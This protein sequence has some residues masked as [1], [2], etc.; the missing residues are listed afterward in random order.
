MAMPD[1]LL[2]L[3]DSRWEE[4][5]FEAEYAAAERAAEFYAAKVRKEGYHVFFEFT[6][7]ESQRLVAR[8][9]CNGYPAKAPDL[10][11]LDP[12]TNGVSGDKRHWPPDS[13]ILQLPDGLHLCIPGTRWF[14]QTHRNR[15]TRE[16]R[17]LARLLAVLAIC[18]NGQAQALAHGRRR[19][20]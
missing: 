8:L 16:D 9:E 17:G 7:R 2:G 13:P 15:G 19:R 18:C 11:F 1:P 3:P 6:G 12:E 4:P 14:E 5:G 20:R 10:V